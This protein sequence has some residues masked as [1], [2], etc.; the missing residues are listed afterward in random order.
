MIEGGRRLSF[1]LALLPHTSPSSCHLPCISIKGMQP[2]PLSALTLPQPCH[3]T[4]YLPTFTTHLLPQALFLPLDIYAQPNHLLP[5][6]M[7]ALES[8]L[9]SGF[10]V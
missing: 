9:A 5:M 8:H 4:I 7:M 10:E 2:P 6:G 3:S 1:V